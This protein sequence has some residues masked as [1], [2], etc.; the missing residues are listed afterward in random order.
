MTREVPSAGY[1]YPDCAVNAWENTST[2][3]AS[4][5][6]ATGCEE[7]AAATAASGWEEEA[8]AAKAATGWEEGGGG[9]SGDGLGAGAIADGSDG[10][11]GGGGGD[12]AGWGEQPQAT[13]A[14]GCEEEAAACSDA[15]I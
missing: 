5:P 11:G 3:L 1:R 10:L 2:H 7:D 8:A 12:S 13:A 14:T 6:T 4:A 15:A 9:E